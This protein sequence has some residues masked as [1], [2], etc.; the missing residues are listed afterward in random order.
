L[1]IA[2]LG[3]ERGDEGEWSFELTPP[4]SRFDGKFYGG[5]GIAVTT[6]IMEAET[7]RAALWATVQFVG[8]ADIGERFD[9]RLEVLAAGRR[10]SQLRMTGMVGDRLVLAAIGATGDARLGPLTA[11][12]GTMP[13]VPSPDETP[14][15]RPNAP[16]SIPQGAESWLSITELRGVALPDHDRVMWARVRDMPQTRATLGF[17]A[18]MVPSRVVSAAGRIGAGTSLDNAMRYGPRP[19]TDWILVEFDPYLA[20]GGYA[21]GGARLWSEDG[22]LLGV[23][24]QT[25]SLILFD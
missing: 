15:W 1:D 2:W 14:E 20:A 10:T 22:T 3:L 23:A 5:T 17:L 18:D 9:C 11:Q 6:A 13:D 12:F 19:E 24:S 16:I 21:H 4:L 8:T 7:G 25:A